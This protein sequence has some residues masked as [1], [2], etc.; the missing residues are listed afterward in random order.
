MQFH[1]RDARTASEDL[2]SMLDP[3]RSGQAARTRTAAMANVRGIAA[4]A[5]ATIVERL[6]GVA[7]PREQVANAVADVFKR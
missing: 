5:A 7:P 3:Q 1:V 4:D 2:A 6:I